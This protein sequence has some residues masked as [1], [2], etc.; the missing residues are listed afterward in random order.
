M[1]VV[2]LSDRFSL[3]DHLTVSCTCLTLCCCRI[4]FLQN[5]QKLI[6]N[7]GHKYRNNNNNA[8]TNFLI[9]LIMTLFFFI[10]SKTFGIT[11]R[12]S[13]AAKLADS[14]HLFAVPI[15]DQQHYTCVGRRKQMQN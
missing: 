5:L 11:S 10:I 6:L 8:E 3:Y 4:R 13:E 14:G 1:I 15:C 12:I 9:F 2:E 7:D